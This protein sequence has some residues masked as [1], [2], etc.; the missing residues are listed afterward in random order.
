VPNSRKSK[1]HVYCKTTT[2]KLLKYEQFFEFQ[3]IKRVSRLSVLVKDTDGKELLAHLTN[4]GR[5][6]EFIYPDAICICVPKKPAKT[7]VRLIG[8]KINQE[9]IVLID[10]AEQS[11]AFKIAIKNAQI[12]WLKNWHIKK[13]EVPV[14]DSRI[15]YEIE[16]KDGKQGYI[17][18]KSAALLLHDKIGS[19]PDCPTERGQK[20]VLLLHRIAKKNIRAI[21]TFIVTHP[22]AD[23]FSPNKVAD[24]IFGKLLK[25]AVKNGVEIKAVKIVLKA[26]GEVV[27]INPD[28]RCII[29]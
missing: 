3:I 13:P 21:I 22:L 5:L 19:F 14:D 12:P 6:Q 4:T 29:Q 20:H 10:P 23:S 1:K 25:N 11:K 26:T 9:T 16:S 7:T 24:P 18:V 8:I 17:E 27:L 2:H 15:D 28:L